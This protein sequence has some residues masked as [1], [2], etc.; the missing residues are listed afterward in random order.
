MTLDELLDQLRVL[1]LIN[2]GNVKVVA[3]EATCGDFD[4]VIHVE[5]AITATLQGD[6]GAVAIDCA[7]APGDESVILIY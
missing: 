4:D 5:K 7:P 2:G 6:T 3:G 1:K